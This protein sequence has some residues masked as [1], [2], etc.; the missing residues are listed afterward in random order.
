MDVSLVEI[1]SLFVNSSYTRAEIIRIFKALE[2]AQRIPRTTAHEIAQDWK[3]VMEEPRAIFDR[4]RIQL[5]NRA[6]ASYSADDLRLAIRGCVLSP[7]HMGTDPSRD[8]KHV[9]N[10]PEVIFKDA[11]SIER[12]IG[13]AQAN[14]ITS[15]AEI[16]RSNYDGSNTEQDSQYT[17]FTPSERI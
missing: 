10:F 17:G 7:W 8:T 16:R 11:A 12:F 2:K 14:N 15:N 4:P 1:E 9:I 13:L 3:T 6:L 5:I